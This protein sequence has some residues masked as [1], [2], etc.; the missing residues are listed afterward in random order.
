MK[1]LHLQGQVCFALLVLHLVLNVVLQEADQVAFDLKYAL[2]TCSEHDHK[3][4]CI[5]IYS[6]MGLYEEAVDLALQVSTSA[7]LIPN[8]LYSLFK[9][10]VDL[11]KQ[12]ADK[13]ED[14]EDLRRKL[15]LKIG[16]CCAAVF[17]LS[18]E[19][20]SPYD[21]Y[22]FHRPWYQLIKQS[23]KVFSNIRNIICQNIRVHV[24]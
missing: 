9:V 6:T 18:H 22:D 5:H 16:T 12:Y 13:P 2:H 15:W 14:D 19:S 10:N 11:A 24:Y 7:G 8:L 4:A 21:M 23:N 3:I 17:Q 20:V 1:Y